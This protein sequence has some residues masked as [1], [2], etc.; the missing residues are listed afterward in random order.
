MR[1]Y[2]LPCQKETGVELVDYGV[3]ER[4]IAYELLRCPEGHHQ[5]RMLPLDPPPSPEDLERRRIY[6]MGGGHGL[7]RRCPARGDEA[8]PG[9]E[10]GHGAADTT[11]GEA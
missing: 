5:P 10:G 9:R 7:R 11:G 4:G 1:R 2:C 6:V 8:G 3:T